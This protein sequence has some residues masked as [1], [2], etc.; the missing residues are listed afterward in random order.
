L[1]VESRGEIPTTCA[2]LAA[3]A[4]SAA[5]HVRRL[6]PG[7]AARPQ[8]VKKLSSRYPARIPCLSPIYSR[9][10]KAV[11]EIASVIHRFSGLD[12]PD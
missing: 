4:C 12:L 7:T 5:M 6:A 11:F 10:T 8:A 3:I 1:T 2:R 9:S